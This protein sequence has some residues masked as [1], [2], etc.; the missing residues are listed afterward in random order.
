MADISIEKDKAQAWI[1]DV[2]QELDQVEKLLSQLAT[3]AGSI[4]GEDDVIM[5]GIGD[6]CESLNEFWT[7]M[8]GGFR[9]A[10]N[11]LGTAIQNIGKTVDSVLSDIKT[12]KNKIGH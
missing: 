11:T 4:P 10:S 2:K 8:C 9:S 5:K 1:Q 3:S 12:V 6:T 7:K